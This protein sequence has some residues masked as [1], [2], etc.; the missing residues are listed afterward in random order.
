MSETTSKAP[1]DVEICECLCRDGLQHEERFLETRRKVELLDRLSSLGFPRLEATSFAH[2]RHVPQF[3][4]AEDVLASIQRRQG[5]IYRATAVNGRGIERA[6]AAAERGFGPD[7]VTLVLSAS[8]PHSELA[9]R[10]D[11][12]QMRADYAEAAPLA[13]DAGLTV[14]G[15]IACAWGSP[16]GDPVSIAQVE[17]LVQFFVDIGCHRVSL[18]DTTG[19]A[20][21]PRVKEYF[22]SLRERHRDTT[23]VAHLHDTRGSAMAN[24]VAAIQ[25]GVRALDSSIGGTGGS[26][27]KITYGAGHTGNLCTEDLV[28]MLERSGVSTGIDVDGLVRLGLETERLFDRT[29]QSRVARL[30]AETGAH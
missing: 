29:L 28:V 6:V 26:P 22:T 8:E 23:F 25:A 3:R 7:E 24:A 27:A 9:Q 12:S 2:P 16:L 14:Q 20:T 13:L 30:H 15:T 18:G 11:H 21:P 19:L 10:R 4:D 5:V 17:Q 1:T